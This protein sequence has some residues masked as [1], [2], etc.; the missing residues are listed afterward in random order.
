MPTNVHN[1]DEI[2]IISN[3]SEVRAENIPSY[4]YLDLINMARE[5]YK[6]PK[7][8]KEYEAWKKEKEKN[9]SA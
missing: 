6:N 1:D 7:N 3:A 9:K 4:I 8:R 2:K 5:F